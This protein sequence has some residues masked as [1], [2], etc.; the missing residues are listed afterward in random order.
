MKARS[1]LEINCP[2]EGRVRFWMD[3][4]GYFTGVGNGLCNQLM[5]IL[6]KYTIKE[7]RE[8]AM[9]VIRGKND[10]RECFVPENLT[11]VLERRLTC[12]NKEHGKYEYLYCL[13]LSFEQP[14]LSCERRRDR[15]IYI[16]S[17]ETLRNGFQF[18]DAD[19]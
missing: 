18:E 11:A 10:G 15:T 4:D 2:E 19:D 16:L 3:T 1:V 7:I 13:D 17:C 6:S 8:M 9:G 14:F 5:S 12:Y